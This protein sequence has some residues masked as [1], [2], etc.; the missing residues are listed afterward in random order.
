MRKM[1]LKG[2]KRRAS[3]AESVHPEKKSKG[4]S[5]N[6]FLNSLQQ[7]ECLTSLK[8]FVNLSKSFETVD[9][10]VFK[11]YLASDA[12]LEEILKCV[13]VNEKK[14]LALATAA[15]SAVRVILMRIL[16]DLP[17]FYIKAE[18]G[19]RYLL[20]AFLPIIN[21]MLSLNSNAHQ[22]KIVLRLLTAVVTVSSEL[23]HEVAVQIT[24]SPPVLELL[25]KHSQASEEKHNVRSCFIHYLLSFFVSG[26]DFTIR[27]L[28]DRKGYINSIIP[29]LLYDSADLVV[30]VLAT[31]RSK[32]LENPSVSKT[33]KLRTFS[34]PIIRSLIGLYE[35]KGPQKWKGDA[36]SLIQQ[37]DEQEGKSVVC[38]SVHE[39]LIVLCTSR[40]HGIAFID[41]TLGTSGNKQN[42]VLYGVL[43]G[44]DQPW[45]NVFTSELVVK[46][47]QL[48]PD[49]VKS[50]LANTE[51]FLPPRPSIKWEKTVSFVEK[52]VT[53]V[54]PEHLKSFA[55]S[56]HKNAHDN[57][58]LSL[59][60]TLTVPTVPL[61][62]VGEAGVTHSHLAVRHRTVLL[63][64]TLL[65]RLRYYQ[66]KLLHWGVSLSADAVSAY[67]IQHLPDAQLIHQTWGKQDDS[68]V[69]Q[70]DRNDGLS[71]PDAG[72]YECALLQLLLLY[73][74][75]CPQLIDI[76]VMSQWI[77]SLLPNLLELEPN[78]D[79]PLMLARATFL[80]LSTDS[81]ILKPDSEIFR[82][83]SLALFSLV[84]QGSKP[85]RQALSA[86]FEASGQL[87]GAQRE[88][89][90]WLHSYTTMV[91]DSQQEVASF[92]VNT[93]QHLAHD[94]ASYLK[95]LQSAEEEASTFQTD[96]LHHVPASSLQ[97]LLDDL[98]E[99]HHTT[100]C[101]ARTMENHES[102]SLLLV[103]ALFTGKE[104]S[105]E[106][107]VGAVP[108]FLSHVVVCLFH[109]QASPSL[110]SSLVHM[111]HCRL[112]PAVVSYIDS[113]FKSPAAHPLGKPFPP[114]CPLRKLS[115]KLLKTDTHID[116][117]PLAIVNFFDSMEVNDDPELIMSLFD[118]TLF[119]ASRLAMHNALT[120][121][122]YE[123][124]KYTLQHLMEIANKLEQPEQLSGLSSIDCV[125]FETASAAQEFVVEK[126]LKVA[127]RN[128]NV[129][130]MFNPLCNDQQQSDM[131]M[132]DLI[133][134][135]M[136]SA[137][138]FVRNKSNLCN[139][140]D[141]LKM[142]FM[143]EIVRQTS[144]KRKRSTEFARDLSNILVCFT[145]EHHE[146]ASLLD[147]VA[148]SPLI[149]LPQ[150]QKLLEYLL[151]KAAY[152]KCG[153]VAGSS[154]AALA[155]FL[156][157]TSDKANTL[158]IQDSIRLL[159]SECPH[160]IGSL[161]QSFF[162]FLLKQ[163][164]KD[165][166]TM[167]SVLL[168]RHNPDFLS[169]FRRTAL[170]KMDIL[171]RASLV[172]SLLTCSSHVQNEMS[173][174][175]EFLRKLY[176]LHGPD[177][178]KSIKKPSKAKSWM[179]TNV[180]GVTLVLDK[181]FDH[182]T[183]SK[184]LPAISE[185]IT[186]MTVVDQF[187]LNL[188]K[189]VFF[190]AWKNENKNTEHI[191]SF[192]KMLLPL[193]VRVLEEGTTSAADLVILPEL[194]NNC[195]DKLNSLTELKVLKGTQLWFNFCRVCLKFGL[196]NENEYHSVLLPLLTRFIS[197]VYE[198]NSNS[199]EAVTLFQMTVSHSR[200]LSVVLGKTQA[201]GNL[202]RLLLMLATR[203]PSVM[204]PEHVPV[205][206]GAY[207]ATLSSTDQL[208][209]QLLQKYESSGVTLERCQPYLWGEAAVNHYS[210][211][212][213]GSSS[214]WQQPHANQ[215][216]DM[217]DSAVLQ[218]T[219]SR[220]PCERDVQVLNNMH[221]DDSSIYD[222]A[223]ILPL[224]S[225][226]LAP[227]S[228]VR[229]QK[230]IHSD[231]LALV[232][233]ALGSECNTTRSA[234]W[235]VIGQ[236]YT[237][238]EATNFGK[239]RHLWLHLLDVIRC[240]AADIMKYGKNDTEFVTPKLSC[241]VST[242]LARASLL[243]SQPLHPLYQPLHNFILAK[244]SLYLLS[245]PEFLPLFHSSDLQHSIH[246]QWI[247]EVIRDGLK[248][249]QDI[250]LCFKCVLFKLLLDYYFSILA[251]TETKVLIVSVLESALKVPGA[252]KLLTN[253]YSVIVWLM[254][255]VD[256]LTSSET[257]LA[258]ALL[259]AIAALPVT[260][261][262]LP[263][264]LINFLTHL[265]ATVLDLCKYLE[266][267][268]SIKVN[269]LDRK[270]LNTLLNKAEEILNNVDDCKM[271]LKYDGKFYIQEDIK[272]I[273][274]E[275][276][277]T[278]LLL[279]NIILTWCCDK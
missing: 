51:S 129:V 136:S 131:L 234:A 142:K 191:L 259:G 233:A 104:D 236:L 27:L 279:K 272:D 163:H 132:T 265:P 12:G 10:D 141:P 252:A 218:T 158:G 149:C 25:V 71:L 29:G 161:P 168:L 96:A 88:L 16:S 246:R 32:V 255:A 267:L 126:C 84:A 97:E 238:L 38:E 80:S 41:R 227:E 11:E 219:V 222:P 210:V 240:G 65:L 95:I 86:L 276:E 173:K 118:Q 137:N 154:I 216:L 147:A 263:A 22:R 181:C 102:S 130:E 243:I 8:S 187:Y 273:Q 75:M 91:P 98:M 171:Q 93:I 175:D 83:V 225:K 90:V 127:L 103:A 74:Q 2:L 196:K 50:T 277:R 188:I 254:A 199:A 203:A 148:L 224:L 159:L 269:L 112:P 21:T 78:K 271:L 270:H 26:S 58:L 190:S 53:S 244:P 275:E 231:A 172:F 261:P 19:C 185:N 155:E 59:V 66:M 72:D 264:L 253:S 214:L 165:S 239:E 122:V 140:L 54:E 186:Q 180:P 262:S 40:K 189:A 166:A 146:V 235:H 184:I 220:F 135:L 18:V 151:K 212:G 241:I 245:I 48:C 197:G 62:V 152:L 179:L 43:Q 138:C 114:S 211:R 209:L 120:L 35:W 182:E 128:K 30:L 3:I 15:F 178:H 266:V 105:D 34:V 230:V 33:N 63:L 201:K 111:P 13:N 119:Y 170:K 143:S 68:L 56:A 169:S 256:R 249:P 82:K 202:V 134:F 57:R 192:V 260:L 160:L 23:A 52:V 117:K 115:K 221:H 247:L 248:S 194:I 207:G 257:G 213:Q 5:V 268:M 125:V 156:M 250:E 258:R 42:P 251:D 121:V 87:E 208:I 167:L 195:T 110:L 14:N 144:S 116:E 64:V 100:T 183:H 145:L 217:L 106:D 4:F 226:L 92:I 198:E 46:I 228:P 206:L 73:Q 77:R 61:R 76:A 174:D 31:L 113:W 81:S 101:M 37:T 1:A 193:I 109:Q 215:V 79:F 28:L 242:F 89:P 39:F 164:S 237:H 278:K 44:L 85:A 108:Y 7:P 60:L 17:Q 133:C 24:L 200:F 229:P 70:D 176:E 36:D 49:L 6:S 123:K 9:D 139:I 69:G 157:T 177:I 47:L 99:D 232:L 204:L 153:Q 45:D 67:L 274:H 55:E 223:F 124:C 20:R 150:W 94:S 162:K 205:L 107:C